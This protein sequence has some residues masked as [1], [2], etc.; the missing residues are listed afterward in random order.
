MDNSLI[1]ALRT[2]LLLL[3]ASSASKALGPLR[4]ANRAGDS[5][6]LREKESISCVLSLQ[7]YQPFLANFRP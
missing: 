2:P 6:E 3:R 5:S 4:F 1:C 7:K